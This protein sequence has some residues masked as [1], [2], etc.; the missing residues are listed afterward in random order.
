MIRMMRTMVWERRLVTLLRHQGLILELKFDL[1]LII[2]RIWAKE[3]S[4]VSLTL[5]VSVCLS[6]CLSLSL[7][8]SLSHS[9][10][11][12]YTDSVSQSFCR[13]HCILLSWQRYPQ[14]ILFEWRKKTN[15]K[16][17]TMWIGKH[18][19]KLLFPLSI[20]LNRIVIERSLGVI[21]KINAIDGGGG[22]VGLK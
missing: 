17:A 2:D 6:V 10:S 1:K 11:K 20:E 12:D 18:L 4:I 22:G 3:Q 21:N 9:L 5:C 13:F 15:G 8:L 16:M 14:K 19:S 7:S